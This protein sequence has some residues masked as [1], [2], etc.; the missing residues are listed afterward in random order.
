MIRTNSLQCT[1]S[2]PPDAAQV[3]SYFLESLSEAWK[4]PLLVYSSRILFST[5]AGVHFG[6]ASLSTS[7]LVT[8]AEHLP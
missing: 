2:R 1:R 6:G 5:A 7:L 8:E 3:H 4:A